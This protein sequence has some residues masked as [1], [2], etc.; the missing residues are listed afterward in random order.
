MTLGWYFGPCTPPGVFH[1]GLDRVAGVHAHVVLVDLATDL[2]AEPPRQLDRAEY[3]L[4]QLIPP[5]TL[6]TSQAPSGD[7]D[8]GRHVVLLQQR[9]S[10]EQVICVAIIEGKDDPAPWGAARRQSPGQIPNGQ[11]PPVAPHNF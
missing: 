9:P 8:G 4:L 3:Q 1:L 2:E 10:L 11:R 5:E 6:T 7:E